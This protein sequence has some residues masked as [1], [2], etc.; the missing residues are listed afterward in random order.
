MC[1]PACNRTAR[2]FENKLQYVKRRAAAS[3]FKNPIYT[4]LRAWSFQTARDLRNQVS[5]V[6]HDAHVQYADDGALINEP[7]LK[8]YMADDP[9][10]TV[11]SMLLQGISDELVWCVSV[12]EVAFHHVVVSVG[13]FVR[14]WS[15]EHPTPC[16]ALVSRMLALHPEDDESAESLWV[17]LTR[18]PGVEMCEGDTVRVDSECWAER[19]ADP[20][21]QETVVVVWEDFRFC[22]LRQHNLR[23][24]Y[25]FMGL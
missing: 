3:N 20:A 15:P 7:L 8:T 2:M 5:A 19:V 11:L 17:V 21:A 16:L 9:A 24:E 23:H 1:G 18:F 13:T 25:L 4:V 12:L 14:H 22:V 6:K 10:F